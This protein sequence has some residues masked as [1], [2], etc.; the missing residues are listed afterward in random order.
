MSGPEPNKS[1][2]KIMFEG[3]DSTG[4]A[5]PKSIAIVIT[6]FP[7]AIF[8]AEGTRD[9]AK[10]HGVKVVE[11]LEYDFGTRDFGP[12]A[13]RVKD[14]D[15][16]LMWL[17]CLGVDGNLLLEA[18]SKF[19]YKPKR[20][21]YLYPSSGPL[22]TLPAAEGAVSGTNFEDVE[23]YISTPIGG[24]FAKAF[25]ERAEKANLPFPHADSQAANEYAGWQILVAAVEATKSLEDKKLAAW[26]EDN[27]VDTVVGK[28]DFK[29]KWHT[30][31]TD[32]GQLRQVQGGKWVTVWPTEDATP[33][34]K[35]MSP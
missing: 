11:Y 12:I 25:R 23:P 18:L 16:D 34:R 7:S 27:S 20:H 31:R 30:S 2:P 28:R 9:F 1:E 22:A 15:P 32:L 8:Q 13:A 35:L 26:L 29:G 33:G 5:P 19:D 4:H 24:A 3:Y 17:G 21:F 6:K 10:E 14:A